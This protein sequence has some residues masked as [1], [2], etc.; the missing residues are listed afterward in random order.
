[1]FVIT[2]FATIRLW[3]LH[4]PPAHAAPFDLY[5]LPKLDPI[6]PRQMASQQGPFTKLNTPTEATR[7][8]VHPAYRV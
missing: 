2:D 5:P 6:R 3:P 4:F 7:A 1:M 8:R